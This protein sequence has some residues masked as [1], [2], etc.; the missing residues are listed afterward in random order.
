M[1]RPTWTSTLRGKV[2][3]TV[4]VAV[5]CQLVALAFDAVEFDR[6]GRS[7]ATVNDA[8][9]PLA[10]A[11][12]RMEGQI[13]RG[14]GERLDATVEEAKAVARNAA[15]N[16][17]DEEEHAHLIAVLQQVE[18][19]VAAEHA[20]RTATTDA[21]VAAD[22]VTARDTLRDEVLQLA[23]LADARIAAVSAKTARAQARAV[24]LSVLLAA[25]TPVLGLVLWWFARN[26][27]APV[28]RLTAL[29]R[30][31]ARGERPEPV[32]LDGDEEI[33][34]LAGAFDQMVR[35]V[36][37]R[38]RNLQ[39]LTLY[40][41][42]VLD[43]IGAAVVVAQGSEIRMANPAA[44]ALWGAREGGDVPA[45][46]ATLAEG[47]HDAML[48]GTRHHDVAVR[49]FGTDG[50]I[51]VGEDVTDRLRDR[52]RLQR[53]ERLAL[54]GQMLAQVTHEVRN[55]LNAMSL[56]AEL[57]AEELQDDEPRAL[58]STIVNEIRRLER[59]TERYLDL[60]R[61]RAPEVAAEDPLALVRSVVALEDE[62]LR[63]AGITTEVIGREMEPV[64]IDGSAVRRALLNLVRNA[65]EA[66]AHR[67][68]VRV[69]RDERALEIRV[70]DDGPGMDAAVAARVFDPFF[71]TRAKG[72]GLGLAITRQSIEDLGGTVVC[73]TS[74]G[75]GTT[76]TLRLPV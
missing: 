39:S 66:G 68:L 49:P 35:A 71:T 20:Y 76:F 54:V 14:N 51:L 43:S 38:D 59:V 6:I 70:E 2:L 8:Y 64:E 7:L 28:S 75:T 57:L 45:A 12:A 13:E 60:A 56:H 25:L 27:L 29:V 40:L 62:V 1:R 30:R 10:R 31:V 36:E 74:L 42:R 48:A 33:V 9:L 21:A 53:S 52:E 3:G 4:L 17:D 46:L 69:G 65:G 16:S 34:T 61:R 73:T 67:V 22:D 37:D 18:D 23:A 50:R 15:E 41:R 24:R 5:L 32:H 58:L 47:R 26:A 63:R 55:P 11:A 72:T 19:I 44:E